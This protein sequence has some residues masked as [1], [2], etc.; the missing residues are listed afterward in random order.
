MTQQPATVERNYLPDQVLIFDYAHGGEPSIIT[1][2]QG[3]QW[4]DEDILKHWN[5]VPMTWSGESFLRLNGFIFHVY[6]DTV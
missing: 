5:M 4:P 6:E 2:V 1:L 3:G